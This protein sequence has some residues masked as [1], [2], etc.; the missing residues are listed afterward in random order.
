MIFVFFT[1][2]PKCIPFPTSNHFFFSHVK[3]VVFW[4]RYLSLRIGSFF[5]KNNFIFEKKE[6]YSIPHL[7]S[8]F[9]K[10]IRVFFATPSNLGFLTH[11]P[12]ASPD[13]QKARRLATSRPPLEDS[14]LFYFFVRRSLHFR[15]SEVSALVVSLGDVCNRYIQYLNK[16]PIATI[17]LHIWMGAKQFIYYLFLIY[18]LFIYYLFLIYLLF[19]YYSPTP[20]HHFE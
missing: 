18:L 16:V 11:S 13:L 19:I 7:K 3:K 20:S 8:C 17:I 6:M 10:K 9:W 15:D 12:G 14:V 2:C 5:V 1:K 4:N